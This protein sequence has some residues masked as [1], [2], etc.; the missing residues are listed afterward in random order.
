MV[1]EVAR[2]M[3]DER[4]NTLAMA[5]AATIPLL[6]LVGSGIDLS[7]TYLAR[8]KLQQACD[9]G[10][11]GG[12]KV[13]GSTVDAA[14]IAE[15]RKYVN[16]NFP[17]GTQQTATFAIDPTEGAN[18]SVD[19][20]LST[21]VP[22]SIMKL[23][24]FGSLA[25]TA[26][27]TGR[28]DFINTDVMLVLDTTLS[29][30]CLPTDGNILC[31]TK[32][33]GSK[34]DALRNGVIEFYRALRPAQTQLEA[35]G[36][37]LRYGIVPYSMSV[38][39]GKLLYA[40]NTTWI[41]NPANYQHCASSGCGS[42][43]LNSVNHSSAWFTSTWEGCVEERQTVATIGPASGYSIP[44]GAHDLDIDS[45]PTNDATRWAP[46]DPAAATAKTSPTS[47]ALQDACP[48][49]ARPLAAFATEADLSTWLNTMVADG[50]TYLDIGLIWGAR[51]FSN[52]GLW[53]T[54]NP[55]SFN[56]FP[57]NRHL[58]LMTDGVMDPDL[59][60]YT[61]YGVE[62]FS[63]GGRRVSGNGNATTQLNSHTQRFRMM[64]N[65][66]KD[67]DI[68]VWVIAFG[69]TSSLTTELQNCASAPTQ[70]FHAANQ[71]ALNAHFT[72]IGQSIGAL[73]LSR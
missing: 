20:T 41:R 9:A 8:N 51:L 50:Y 17:Q 15:V 61:T 46:Y 22:T 71:A 27:C 21:T 47:A 73:R 30:N 16:F 3:R 34:I 59:D 49:E 56:S 32:K 52:T 69:S 44:S 64:C 53:S 6:G 19:L 31:T 5:A 35:A 72:Q 10:V 65:K 67:M 58:I 48:K 45:A 29:M 1:R 42:P 14:V 62:K 4:G 24:G 68:S 43:T 54:D 12:R 55:L 37:R 63:T 2:L 38:N 13:M 11:L 39:I 70:A 7:R 26:S 36:L 23:F 25:I 33:T 60:V 28:Q 18:K 66:L 40:K 57:V